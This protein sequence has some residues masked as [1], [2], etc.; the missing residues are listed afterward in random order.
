MIYNCGVF[1]EI[2]ENMVNTFLVFS[3]YK[4]SAKLLDYK[5]LGK[6]RVEAYQILNICCW[7]IGLGKIYNEKLP[8]DPYK[9]YDWIR[10]ITKIYKADSHFYVFSSRFVESEKMD[11][12]TTS[13][14]K[15]FSKTNSYYKLK[16]SDEFVILDDSVLCKNSTYPRKYCIFPDEFFVDK[17]TFV[18]H[19]AVLMWICYTE[20]LKDYIN[21][22]V[23]EW[24]ARG[25]KNSYPKL[26]V[27][28]SI[29]PFWTN[30]YEFHKRHRSNL[31]RKL[32]KGYN[33]KEPNNLEYFWPFTPK[34]SNGLSDFDQKYKLKN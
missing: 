32:E 8:T 25:Y 34:C 33:F 29:N 11:F 30:D 23:E 12:S 27:E 7:L 15:M 9:V 10:L 22:H 5:K 3:N 1:F 6:Q 13:D 24:V 2:K 14:Y 21:A 18:Y 19:P 16:F 17:L 4:E 20:S 31:V 26:K 28:S